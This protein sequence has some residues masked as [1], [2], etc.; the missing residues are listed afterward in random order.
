MK[1]R[2][3]TPDAYTYTI[4][5]RGC[6]EHPLP[7]QA[8]PRVITIYNSMMAEKSPIRPNTIHMNAVLKMCAKAG[9][10][11]ALFAIAS[12]LPAKGSRAPNKLTYTIIFNAIRVH[13]LT[14]LR[15]NLTEVQKRKIR[16]QATQDA[17]HFWTHVVQ[18]WR[19]GDILIDEELVCTMGRVLLLGEDEDIDDVL[20][21]IEQTMDIPRQAPSIRHRKSE[22]NA[23]KEAKVKANRGKEDAA[24]SSKTIVPD[25]DADASL[26]PLHED[27]SESGDSSTTVA[28]VTKIGKLF[29]RPG[30]NTL[31]LLMEAI[32]DLRIKEPAS[33]YW[34]ILTSEYGVDPDAANYHGYLRILRVARA[35]T[36]TVKVLSRMPQQ[37]MEVKTFRIAMSTCHRDKNNQHA[38]ANAGK[39]LDF[40]QTAF[41]IPDTQ[42]LCD[43]LESAFSVG[44]YS[45]KASSNGEHGSSKYEQG[46]QVMRALARLNPS[47]VNLRSLV[48]YGDP[49]KPTL[50][51]DEKAHLVDSVLTLTRRL[52]SAYD[53]LI[54][55]EMVSRDQFDDLIGQRRK[56]A[57]FVTRFKDRKNLIQRK[58]PSGGLPMEVEKDRDLYG[59]T[60]P[61]VRR[62]MAGAKSAGPGV[63]ETLAKDTADSNKESL[64]EK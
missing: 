64:E 57:A 43:Y 17:R 21:L 44:A 22:E 24:T 25:Y 19:Q 10:M 12:D 34:H 35:S 37:Y 29:T 8:L 50:K 9:D 38:F 20:T 58:T 33:K 60:K 26:T 46:K 56:L 1:K 14:S 16:R 62:R 13:V 40:M 27:K 31:S 41:P 39:V 51:N 53:F 18:R 63:D 3:Q 59:M 7:A 42:V 15:G 2:A 48:A 52:V 36:E 47:Y 55:K 4:I 49:S 61:A 32:L 45:K 28:L 5:F 11:D 6:A 23:L 30:Q 54:H